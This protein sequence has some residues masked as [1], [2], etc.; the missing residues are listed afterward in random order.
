MTLGKCRGKMWK[1]TQK[2]LVSKPLR[3]AM[4]HPVAYSLQ[5]VAATLCGNAEVTKLYSVH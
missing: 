3:K 4:E 2:E 5:T 1:D